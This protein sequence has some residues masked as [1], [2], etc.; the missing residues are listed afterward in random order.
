[1]R[2]AKRYFNDLNPYLRLIRQINTYSI[3]IPKMPVS[4]NEKKTFLYYE[5]AFFTYLNPS[6]MHFYI[7]CA[8]TRL[9]PA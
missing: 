4:M 9:A 7:Y 5:N 3:I 2:A 8:T 6:Q 1:M